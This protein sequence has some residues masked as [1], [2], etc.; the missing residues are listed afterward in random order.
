[1]ISLRRFSDLHPEVT[2]ALPWCRARFAMSYVTVQS[3]EMNHPRVTTTRTSERP[4]KFLVS[5]IHLAVSVPFYK[6]SLDISLDPFCFYLAKAA[7]MASKTS[8]STRA[9]ALSCSVALDPIT[10]WA[11]ARP[12]RTAFCSPMCVSTQR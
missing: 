9:S 8:T 1:M 11:S 10:R 2:I 5:S 4:G 7:W 3:C 6:L 12:A